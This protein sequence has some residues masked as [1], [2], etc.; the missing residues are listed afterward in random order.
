MRAKKSALELLDFTLLQAYYKFVHI[1]N[2]GLDPDEVVKDYPID[3]DFLVRTEDE[4][5]FRIFLKIAVNDEEQLP[6]YSLLL[7]GVATFTFESEPE[8]SKSEKASYLQT[9]GLSICINNLRN[10]IS[11][12]TYNGPYSVYLLP[13]IDLNDL[14]DKKREMIQNSKPVKKK[15]RIAKNN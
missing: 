13:A 12:L 2:H 5:E 8:I 4:Q 6:G 1:E 10:I 7:E 9:S 15:R 14:L 11:A 3:I